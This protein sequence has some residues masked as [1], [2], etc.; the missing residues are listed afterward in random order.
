MVGLMTAAPAIARMTTREVTAQVI[1]GGHEIIEQ[2]A[3]AWRELCDESRCPPFFRP[4]WI[5]TYLRAFE[6]RS[7]VALFTAHSGESLIAVL[8]MVRKKAWYAG[9][10]VTKL[11]GAANVHSVRYG[12]VRSK[13]AA[14]KDA[15]AAIWHRIRQSG[16]WHVLELPMVAEGGACGELVKLAQ[17][18]G[19]RT[20]TFPVQDSPVLHMTR[21]ADGRLTCFGGTNRHFR[22]ELR[23]FARLLEEIAGGKPRLQRFDHPEPSVMRQFY[24]LEAAGWKGNEGSAINCDPARRAFYDAIA[25]EASQ[26]D[27]FSLHTLDVEGKMAAGAFSVTTDD[28]FYPMKIA[29]N[30]EWRRGA[31]GHLLFN[32]ILEECARRNIPELFFGGNKDRY[33]TAWTQDSIAH[34]DGVIFA[35]S[36]RGQLAFHLRTQLMS[37]LGHWR[38][39]FLAWKIKRNKS[40]QEKSKTAQSNTAAGAQNNH[41]IEGEGQS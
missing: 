14:G 36:L 20:L 23:R 6:P 15:V 30:E 5:A 4:E 13:C 29:H 34:H 37:R 17:Q 3:D 39:D 16:G 21:D 22:H 32:G 12:M 41:N 10:P 25:Q 1:F 2:C 7:E 38:R 40:Q 11:C 9:V 35:P 19:Y 28:C 24:E 18:D 26:R 27:Y 8:P 31:P 33:K